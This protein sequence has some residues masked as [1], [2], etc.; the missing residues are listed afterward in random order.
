MDTYFS[1][2]WTLWDFLRFVSPSVLS[3]V[4]VSLYV[5][6][7]AIFIARYAGPYAMAA[8]NILMPFYSITFG[9]GIMMAA[10][11]SAI[12]G[13]ELGRGNRG[14]A[15]SLFS[16]SIAAMTAACL[17]VIL[18]AVV[19]GLERL[20]LLLGATPALLPYCVRYLAT[21]ITGMGAVMLQVCFEYF[22]RLDG[23][24]M[25]A[26]YIT[27]TAGVINI[28]LDY[29]FIV[30]MGMGIGG[31]GIASSAGI[32]AAVATGFYYFTRRAQTL[33]FRRFTA[34]FRFLR[35]AAVNGSSEMVTEAAAGVKI[36]VFNYIVLKYAGEFG[37]AAMS[38]LMYMYFL[39]SSVHIG[40]SM[41]VSPVI[42]FNFGSRRFI[43]IRELLKMSGGV[44]AF[45]SAVVFAVSLTLGDAII[46]LFTGGHAEVTAIAS[47]GL[48]F[49]AYAFLLE[50]ASILASGFFTS[51]NNGKISALISFMRSFVFTL[52]L[53][54]V[55][56][57]FL[58][59]DGVWLSVPLAEVGALSLSVLFFLKYRSVYVTPEGSSA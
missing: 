31:A 34:D 59:L 44:V 42:S 16:L 52:G 28:A 37:V 35:D 50:G 21:L 32:L 47:R 56:P 58:G 18:F 26:L 25:W 13:I 33:R 30:R 54:A 4:S 39:L 19:F 43:K 9:I 5:V 49:F 45:T 15:D 8:V 55:L 2:K 12:I 17:G 27:L 57:P 29:L 14:R 36:L 1:S 22:M 24:P 53:V 23:R 41:G 20:S 6:V 11:A 10:G 40:L 38:V 48:G 7:D 3:I 46:D 51:V